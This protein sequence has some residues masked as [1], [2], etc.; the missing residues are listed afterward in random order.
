M[1]LLN[2]VWPNIFETSPHVINAVFEAIE[3]C[4]CVVCVSPWNRSLRIMAVLSRGMSSAD[5]FDVRL[6]LSVQA[7]PF[8]SLPDLRRFACPHEKVLINSRRE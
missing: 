8:L 2:F 3:V 7:F 4:V 1:H 5:A 6:E